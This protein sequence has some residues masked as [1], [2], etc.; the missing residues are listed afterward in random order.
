LIRPPFYRADAGCAFKLKYDLQVHVIN[1]CAHGAG[2][3][4]MTQV[5]PCP[6]LALGA[7]VLALCGLIIVG[8]L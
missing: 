3:K 7:I 2:V 1:H 5:V 6:L 8:T 4:V